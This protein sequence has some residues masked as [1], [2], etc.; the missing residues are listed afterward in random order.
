MRSSGFYI[1]GSWFGGRNYPN[2]A[3]NLL[4]RTVNVRSNNR[5]D[6]EGGVG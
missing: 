5:L 6:L 1:N 4:R 3:G 2:L